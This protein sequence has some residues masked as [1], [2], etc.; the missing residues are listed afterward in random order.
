MNPNKITCSG[1][2]LGGKAETSE[3][4]QNKPL[5]S[6]SL[7]IARIPIKSC[8][9]KGF[10]AGR[11][12]PQKSTKTSLWFQIA[13]G[14]PQLCLKSH[15]LLAR[16]GQ[17]GF[18]ESCFFHLPA[19]VPRAPQTHPKSDAPRYPKGFP[20]LSLKTQWLSTRPGRPGL[21]ET[22]FFHLPTG[23]PRASS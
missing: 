12:K 23:A 9:L 5:A 4:Y 13:K 22:C 15:W 19:G 17:P 3:I 8:V 20:Q 14:Y 6:K 2:V 16:A 21:A 18:A 1:G 7:I 10:W 11:P